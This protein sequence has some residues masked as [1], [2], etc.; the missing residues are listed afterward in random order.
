M[1][2]IKSNLDG[3][4]KRL[5]TT[6]LI[7]AGEVFHKIENYHYISEPTFS[8]VQV[9]SSQN[10]EEFDYMANLNHSCA[11]NIFLDTNRLELRAIRDIEPGEELSFFYPSTEWDMAAPFE[12]LCGSTQCLGDV[13]GAKHLSLNVLSQHLLNHHIRSMALSC[14]SDKLSSTV[15]ADQKAYALVS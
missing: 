1:L 8:S 10:I 4:G 5:T 9:G 2:V 12:C 6:R 7:A 14:L 11:P 3:K 13:T 15:T